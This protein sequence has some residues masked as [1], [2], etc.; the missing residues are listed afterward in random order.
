MQDKANYQ[1]LTRLIK[2]DIMGKHAEEDTEQDSY[3]E[4]VSL[5]LA[6]P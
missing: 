6:A 5:F 2:T 1:K 4:K 3:D